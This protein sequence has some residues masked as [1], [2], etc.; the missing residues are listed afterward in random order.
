MS[1]VRFIYCHPRGEE[2]VRLHWDQFP[3]ALIIVD[4]ECPPD[5][6][7]YRAEPLDPI[8]PMPEW[9]PAWAL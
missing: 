4:P 7:F 2:T 3:G 8:E 6:A 1:D 5:L 9:A